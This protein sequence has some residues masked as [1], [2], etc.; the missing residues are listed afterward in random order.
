MYRRLGIRYPTRGKELTKIFPSDFISDLE[1]TYT[2]A[3]EFALDLGAIAAAQIRTFA[4][5]GKHLQAASNQVGG[6]FEPD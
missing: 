4:A 6:G 1:S 3:G 2:Q 5:L